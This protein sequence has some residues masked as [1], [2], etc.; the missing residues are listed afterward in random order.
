[1]QANIAIVIAAFNRPDSLE[2][3]LQSI[4]RADYRDYKDIP[5]VISIDFS[6][7]DHCYEVAENFVWQFGDKIIIKHPH[8][9]KLKTHIIQCGDLTEQ[10][11]AIIML[12]DDLYV[13]SQFFDYAQKAFFFYKEDTSLAGIGLYNYR[14]NEFAYCPFEPITDGYDNYFMQIPCSWGQI[15]TRYQWNSFKEY[16]RSE[17]EYEDDIL[18]PPAAKIWPIKTS[19]KRSFFK[20]MV[21]K[22]KYFVYPRVSLTTNFGDIGDHYSEAVYIWQTP[23]LYGKR[24][25]RFSYITESVS[26]YD[27]FFELDEIA[28]NKIT[29]QNMS[30]SFDLNGSKPLDKIKSEYLVSNKYCNAPIKKY[31]PALYPYEC[32]A[33][34]EVTTGLSATNTFSFGKTMSFQEQPAFERLNVD[35]QRT[36]FNSGFLTNAAKVEVYN[37]V[38]YRLGLFI[39]KPYNFS[40]RLIRKLGSLITK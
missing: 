21:A 18:M 23:L 24:D 28:Y 40:K 36:F 30:I 39:F 6:G 22:K 34:N 4:A 17:T 20:Y 19:W 12:E 26:I 13:S 5:L 3:L 31:L 25:Y 35:L 27:N 10:Y 2:R 9:L 16:F 37:S 1:M 33:I 38:I 7:N 14:Y 8:N 15:W 29:S 32:N 11:D